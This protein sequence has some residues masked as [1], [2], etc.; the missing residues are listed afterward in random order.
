MK[1]VK[2][3]KISREKI[4]YKLLEGEHYKNYRSFKKDGINFCHYFMCCM[5][6]F[7][8]LYSGFW[9]FS[10]FNSTIAYISVRLALSVYVL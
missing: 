1:S 6:R 5:D 3:E 9:S 2:G 7:S 8:N 4:G 10:C